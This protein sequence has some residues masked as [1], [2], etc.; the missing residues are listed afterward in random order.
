MVVSEGRKRGVL[1]TAEEA[2]V[3]DEF[4]HAVPMPPWCDEDGAEMS[5]LCG[6]TKAGWK[7]ASESAKPKCP[8]CE[9]RMASLEALM[10]L[11][12]LEEAL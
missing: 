6:Y 11:L 10:E 1:L 4:Q 12:E 8:D 2:A 5:A 9:R 7:D 3:L